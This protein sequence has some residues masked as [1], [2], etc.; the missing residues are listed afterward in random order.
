MNRKTRILATVAVI[1]LAMAMAWHIGKDRLA[2]EAARVSDDPLSE[3]IGARWGGGL[4]AGFAQETADDLASAG[5]L[6]ARLTYRKPVDDLLEQWE[7]ADESAQAAFDRLVDAHLAAAIPEEHRSLLT[8]ARPQIGADW[9][10]YT[11]AKD[12]AEI[13]LL[14][15][16]TA[17]VM[18]L[19]EYQP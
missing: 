11:A 13:I 10:A 16:K 14:Y 1:V 6:F 18:Y 2:Q 4:P 3:G 15:D 5:R 19:A 7:A 17:R 8:A 12:G 9:L